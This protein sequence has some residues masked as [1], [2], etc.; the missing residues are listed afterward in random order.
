MTLLLAF[1][2]REIKTAIRQHLRE[3]AADDLVRCVAEHQLSRGVEGLDR[4]GFINADDPIDVIFD[5]R[6]HHVAPPLSV[7]AGAHDTQGLLVDP[8]DEGRHVGEKDRNDERATVDHKCIL[9]GIII[10]L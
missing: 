3:W 8:V 2:G 1:R 6:V 5:E 7:H 9:R 10:L 4:P